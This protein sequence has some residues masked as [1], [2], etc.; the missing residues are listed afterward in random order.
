MWLM[1]AIICLILAGYKS[2]TM[3]M[4]D[5]LFFLMFSAL[6]TVLWLLRRRMRI[7]MENQQ[8]SQD[9]SSE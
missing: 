1:V 2:V 3:S 8:N 4:E 5:G 6:A 9:E 7:R